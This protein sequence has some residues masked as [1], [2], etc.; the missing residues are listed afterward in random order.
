MKYLV[1]ADF[2]LCSSDEEKTTQYR[3]FE[4]KLDAFFYM[5]GLKNI[6]TN[7]V[8][9]YKKINLELIESEE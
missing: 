4:T 2:V 5:K 1:V 8:N 3:E 6:A 7:Y 9:C